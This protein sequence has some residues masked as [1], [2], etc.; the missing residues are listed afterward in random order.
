MYPIGRHKTD[1]AGS[2][3]ASSA[4]DVMVGLAFDV[5]AELEEVVAMRFLGPGDPTV[6]ANGEAERFGCCLHSERGDVS[7]VTLLTAY[8][9][10]RFSSVDRILPLC[11]K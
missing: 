7:H 3:H 1:R 8:D 11:R 4:T 2:E 5:E 9:D 10:G 6:I